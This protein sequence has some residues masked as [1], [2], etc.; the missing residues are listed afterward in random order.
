MMV[1]ICFFERLGGILAK[2]QFPKWT[3]APAAIEAV[4]DHG[5]IA[6]W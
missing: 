4:S 2:W 1:S 3:G 5:G 6:A